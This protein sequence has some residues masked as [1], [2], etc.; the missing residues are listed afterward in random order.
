MHELSVC[1]SL[2][3]QVAEVAAGHDSSR[4]SSVTVRVGA[5]S[6]VEPDLLRQ[7]FIVARAGGVAAEADLIIEPDPVRIHCLECET[8]HGVAPNRLLCPACGNYR[9]RLVG[10]EDLIL[11]SVALETA[12]TRTSPTTE[13]GEAHV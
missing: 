9:V 2:L 7:A 10:G 12:N 13:N 3:A 5:L 11:A 6:G 4:V 8:E 1:Q